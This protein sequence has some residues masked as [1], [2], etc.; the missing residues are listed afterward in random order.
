MILNNVSLDSDCKEDIFVSL[1]GIIAQE[2][3]ELLPTAVREVG[4]VAY[5]DG[6]KIHNFLMVDKVSTR[7]P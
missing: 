2:V 1:S 5:S 4:D 6:Q 7:A 3:R